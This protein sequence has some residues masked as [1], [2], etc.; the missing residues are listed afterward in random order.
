MPNPPSLN[1]DPEEADD[2]DLDAVVVETATPASLV[3]LLPLLRITARLSAFTSTPEEAE[4]LCRALKGQ[5]FIETPPVFL[6]EDLAACCEDTALLAIE[7]GI[8]LALLASRIRA[9]PPAEAFLLFAGTTLLWAIR[10]KYPQAKVR[11]F[12]RVCDT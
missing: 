12:M 2:L 4:F 3:Q 11:D 5:E 7:T 8:D 6:A 1:M 10:V 9:L